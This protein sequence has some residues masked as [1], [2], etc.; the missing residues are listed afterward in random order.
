MSQATA[1]QALTQAYRATKDRAYLRARRPGAPGA[2]ARDRRSGSASRRGAGAATSCT[3]SRPG[4]AVI[5]GFLQTLIGLYDYANVS[6]DGRA[7][8][9]FAA[10]R[11]RGPG[12]A[13][14]LRHRRV[15]AVPAR[16][17]SRRS[18]TTS[19]SPA[20]CRPC[21]GSPGPR[22]TAPSAGGSTPT[23][24][25]RRRSRCSPRRSARA[26]RRRFASGSRSCPTSGR[27]SA[28]PAARRTSTRAPRSRTASAAS[29]CRR[30]PPRSLFGRPLRDGPGRQLPPHDG[31][32]HR[33]PIRLVDSP[34]RWEIRADD[35]ADDPVHRQGR[36]G[37]DL[38]RRRHRTAVRGRRAADARAVDRSGPQPVRDPRRRAGRRPGSDRAAA[39]G[40]GGRRPAGDGA[41]LGG[42]SGLARRAAHRPRHRSDLRR[43]AHRPPRDGRAVRAAHAPAPQHRRGVR[44]DHRRLRADRRDAAAAVVPRCRPLVAGEGLPRRASAARGRPPD[45]P[46]PARR[47]PARPGEA[48]GD[49]HRLVPVARRHE[50]DPPRPG[51]DARSAS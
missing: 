8:R 35:P 24:T 29:R 48:L 16:R 5:N 32:P 15:V 30:S 9:L 1:L 3:R 49:V 7:Q 12:R 14:E 19:S 11:R 37:Q 42:G 22:C 46:D 17:R 20:S 36:R 26:R 44:R 41:P 38:R 25:P 34:D 6:H 40:P 50:R 18:T 43:G 13:A 31:G 28:G 33:D 2:R 47:P 4:E 21:A 51:T 39:V 23:S 27:S 10:G 45:C